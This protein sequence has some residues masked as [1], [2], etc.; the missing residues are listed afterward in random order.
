MLICGLVMFHILLPQI[1][2][3][4]WEIESV[5]R[6]VDVRIL[7]IRCAGSI[8][9]HYFI[10]YFKNALP[11]IPSNQSNIEAG[12]KNKPRKDNYKLGSICLIE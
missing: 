11:K 10:D 3:K 2:S 12:I 1:F 9:Y 7:N 5:Y 4:P 6:P 8:V